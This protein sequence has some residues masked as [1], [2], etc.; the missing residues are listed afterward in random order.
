MTIWIVLIIALS[1]F[2]AILHLRHRKKLEKE[3]DEKTELVKQGVECGGQILSTTTTFG[4]LAALWM[5]SYGKM[6][7]EKWIYP[8]PRVRTDDPCC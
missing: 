5:A 6:Q 2:L 7:S 1:L 3:L 4:D 8:H